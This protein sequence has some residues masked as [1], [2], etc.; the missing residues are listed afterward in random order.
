[1]PYNSLLCDVD[2][3]VAVVTINRPGK[4]NALN[5]EVVDDLEACFK[6]L[7]AQTEVRAV[8]LTGAGEKAFVAGADITQFS[9]LSPE[10][11]ASFA[12]R[13]QEVFN[14][15]ESGPK[16]VVAAVNGYALGGGCELALACHIR[17][18]SD[19]ASLGQPE[20]NLGVIPGYGGTQRL[21]RVVGRGVA[22]EMILT[23]DPITAERAL[24]VGLVN[25]ITTQEEL[26]PTARKLAKRIASR[27][28]VAVRLST[29]AVLR[30][31]L[32]LRDGLQQEADLFGQSFA[33]E[34]VK[35]GVTAF[36]ER[37]KPEFRGQ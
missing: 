2:E 16:P 14:L 24:A 12:R 33:T 18:A 35:E 19:N 3:G 10:D 27:G 26:L 20:V 11:A 25:R 37:R 5:A 8:V 15:I 28:P 17:L 21:P 36:L 13:G 22:L 7:H 31:D 30:S 9:G 32:P 4:L 34:D 23:G 1:M 6:D 29:A